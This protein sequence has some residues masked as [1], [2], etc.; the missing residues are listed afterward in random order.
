MHSLHAARTAE[1]EKKYVDS[2]TTENCT[3]A[4]LD[5]QL[6]CL[7]NWITACTLLHLLHILLIRLEI[8]R[9]WSR[10]RQEVFT[11]VFVLLEAFSRVRLG[12]VYAIPVRRLAYDKSS[13]RSGEMRTA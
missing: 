9:Y 11:M 1:V 4:L 10:Q 8:E 3:R 13:G 2:V 5:G 12:P 6:P 7:L